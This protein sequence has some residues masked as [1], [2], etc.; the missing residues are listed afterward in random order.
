MNTGELE[1]LRAE[2]AERVHPAPDRL[3]RAVR[4]PGRRVGQLDGV[5]AREV[6]LVL[7]DQFV[8]VGVLRL[9][10]AL[11]GVAEHGRGDAAALA[12]E[13]LAAVELHLLLG[14]PLRVLVALLDR[15]HVG[16]QLLQPARGAQRAQREREG[17]HAREDR[18]HEN[19]DAVR[20]E[21]EDGQ[22]D[23]QVDERVLEERL[24]DGADWEH[25]RLAPLEE[26][27]RRPVAGI[28]GDQV[29]A[30]SDVQ[31]G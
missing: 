4:G 7:L 1:Q 31:D 9:P 26:D 27:G 30:V 3:A 23:H 10:V 12:G 17:D 2:A 29:A 15:L 13:G 24:P 25:G 6:A 11:D 21:R 14:A 28:D 20:P 18:K 22:Q 16:L 8:L 19:G 5:D